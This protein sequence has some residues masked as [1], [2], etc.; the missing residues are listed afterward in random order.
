MKDRRGHTVRRH[1]ERSDESYTAAP[2]RPRT[3]RRR[4]VLHDGERPGGVPQ[5]LRQRPVPSRGAVLRQ[6]ARERGAERQS[7]KRFC[8]GPLALVGTVGDESHE[9]GPLV[10]FEEPV[11]GGI[12]LEHAAVRDVYGVVAVRE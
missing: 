12:E 11:E 6:V 5:S 1:A 2:N 8:A 4:V 10:G 3:E 7:P 9:F